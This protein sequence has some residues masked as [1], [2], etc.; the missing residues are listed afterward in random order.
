MKYHM[1]AYM[2]S[3]YLEIVN[4]HTQKMLQLWKLMMN[5][6]EIEYCGSKSLDM[7]RHEQ[8]NSLATWTWLKWQMTTEFN[9]WNVIGFFFLSSSN[10][11][12]NNNR[13]I[14]PNFTIN[15]VNIRKTRCRWRTLDKKPKSKMKCQCKHKIRF[16]ICSSF[17]MAWNPSSLQWRMF[18]SLSSFMRASDDLTTCLRNQM[19]VC[20]CGISFKL[21]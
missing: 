20:V 18:C 12:N 17:S 21:S 6:L 4:T 7:Y 11:T 1:H 2:V 3:A 19:D 5:K 13:V 15:A 14:K 8:I 16:L 10:M 9:E